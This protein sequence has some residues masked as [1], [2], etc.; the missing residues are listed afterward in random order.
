MIS[1]VFLTV[2]S[3]VAVFVTGQIIV[4]IGIDPYIA[5]KE[6]TGRISALLLREQAK[7]VNGVSTADLILELK[8]ASALLLA[9]YSAVP[10][11]LKKSYLRRRVLPSKSNVLK[12]A[13]NL[14]LI[15]SALEGN[16]H[17]TYYYYI[18]E[19]GTSLDIPTTY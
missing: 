4:K 1:S 16:E 9:K 10:C 8:D 18:S 12:A 2:F 14:N 3:G 7:I 13:H 5:F 15:S 11:C 6:Q 19:I 17:A